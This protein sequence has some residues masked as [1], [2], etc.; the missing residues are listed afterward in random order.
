MTAILLQLA[1]LAAIGFCGCT[2]GWIL[3]RADKN[4][5]TGALVLCQILIMV[6]CLP[7]LFLAFPMSRAG[8][9]ILYGVSYIGISFIGPSWLMFSYFYCSGKTKIRILPL[10]YGISLINYSIFLTNELH[11][12]FYLR[13][14]L[15]EVIYGPAFYFHMAYTYV[16]VLAGAAAVLSGFRK[17]KVP[18]VHMVMI[19]L[20]AAA[21]LIFNVLY[22]SGT[23]RSGFDLT[24]PVFALSSF[25]MLLAVFRYD[26]LDVD[27]AASRQI[28]SSIAE[29]IVISNRRGTVT[30]CNQTAS[31][32]AE[33]KNG[34]H[35]EDILKKF[36]F[37]NIQNHE[38]T[39]HMPDGKT[40]RLREY[41]L[42]G[43][44]GKEKARILVLTDISEYYE[45]VRQSREL[46]V[47]Q[48]RLAIEQERNRIAQEVHDTTGH[49]LTM[50]NSLIK[51]IALSYGEECREQGQPGSREMEE[52]LCQARKLASDGI[53][54][55]RW[56]I[57]HL[58]NGTECELVS[59]GVYQLAASVR[60]VEVEVEIQGEDGPGYSHL[61][62]VVYQCLREAITNCLRYAHAS[63]M[64]VIVKFGDGDVS[65]YIFDDGQGCASVRESH[66]LQGIRERADRAGGTVRFWSAEG[67]GFQIFLQ[68]P[69]NIL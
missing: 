21:P 34:D 47:S 36:S 39:V 44:R 22:L 51:L 64:D 67:E 16:C 55:L 48:Q 33:V 50:L 19:I 1:Y 42:F 4:R 17:K 56:S 35:Y 11:H 9:Y 2:A 8:K 23:V 20:A 66:G 6:W 63:H 28:F 26:F 10:M 27:T 46:A 41:R 30:Y 57:N 3:L 18:G 59:Q 37:D 53:R 12:L 25:L 31:L 62:G 7:Q 5:A 43:R 49:T 29:G 54:E 58:R 40:L 61:S 24:P 38:T 13:F 14:E 45:L 15:E 65:M 32:W 52:Y 69:I 60:E 68:L